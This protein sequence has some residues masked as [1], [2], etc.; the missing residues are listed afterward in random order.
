M[1]QLMILVLVCFLMPL[2]ATAQQPP[3]PPQRWDVPPPPPPP[4]PPPAGSG[5]WWKNSSTVRTLELTENQ[6]AQLEAVFLQYQDLLA[7]LRQSLLDHEAQLKT[8]LA[9]DRLDEAAFAGQRAQ[10]S[11]ARLELE[12]QNSEMTLAMRRLMTG[13]QWRRLEKLRD[14]KVQLPVPPPPPPPPPPIKGSSA[15]EKV[16]DLK[17]T[18]GLQA[19]TAGTQPKPPYTDEA[20]AAKI[21]G[22]LILEAIIRSD[23]SIGDVR[24]LRSLG[25]GLDESALETVKTRWVFRPAILQGKPVNARATFEISFRLF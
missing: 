5:K 8:L 4:P 10:L 14:A 2:A 20:R 13:E 11:A 22:V 25:H 24:V 17:T 1:K 18:P 23:G 6:V 12:N 21:E 3:N 19:P 16:Y 7:R 9:A 15:A